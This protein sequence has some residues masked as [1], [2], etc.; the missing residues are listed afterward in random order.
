ML[1]LKLVKIKAIRIISF[2]KAK[3]TQEV[4]MSRTHFL[5]SAIDHTYKYMVE[6]SYIL[7]WPKLTI[8]GIERDRTK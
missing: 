6:V 7:I 3:E 5:C 2:H 8:K 4:K 1:L